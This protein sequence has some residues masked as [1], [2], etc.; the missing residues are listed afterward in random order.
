MRSSGTV[1]AMARRASD[2]LNVTTPEKEIESPSSSPVA[3]SAAEEVKQCSTAVKR[4][5][6]I[7]SRRMAAMSS[8]ASREWIT[9]GR[10]VSRAAAIWVRNTRSA[11]SRGA[12]S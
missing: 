6:P 12:A 1:P 4:P 9:N 7:S 2:D 5:R 11:T 3:A 10:P 8:S